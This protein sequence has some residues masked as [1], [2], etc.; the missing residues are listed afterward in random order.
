MRERLK[1]NIGLKLLAFLF[2]FILWLLVVNIDDP[3]KTKT[4]DN[5]PV[6]VEHEEVITTTDTK[7][8]QIIDNTQ[9]VSVSISAVRSVL[10]KIK[11]EDIVA[12][13][14]MRELYLD[15]LVPI[16]VQVRGYKVD[17]AVA[18]PR[19]LRVK[20]ENN[21]SN[22]FPI[23]PVTTGTVRDGY[24]LGTI[25]ADP[26]KVTINGPESVV[27]RISKVIAEV[28]VSGLSQDTKLESSLTL[29]DA[30]NN[31]I[32]QSLLGNNLGKIGVNIDV[33]LLHTK[34]VPVHVDQTSIEAADGFSV[35]GVSYSPQEI[36]LAGEEEVLSHITGIYVPAEAI[37]EEK[38]SRKMEKTI[39]ITPYLPEHTRLVDETGNNLL[40]TITVEKDGTRNLDLP[41]GSISVKN[42]DD[43][44]KMSYAGTDDLE[45]HIR[46]PRE[47]L[48]NYEV[49]KKASI[50]LSELKMA[51]TYTVSVEIELPAGCTLENKV[52]VQ[53]VLEKKEESGG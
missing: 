53:V 34:S 2:A 28:D 9:T 31:V 17:S 6:V 37:G 52:E 50:D 24:V 16:E 5:I 44:L 27:E 8:Y 1:N 26:E 4:Y 42:L 46:G 10:S 19:N 20:I 43:S 30:E 49:D 14:D 51:G 15:S 35:A 33:T 21:A 39:D 29:Y 11:A 38:I 47:V 3:V 18:N 45:I 12:V 7:T 48:E 36:L 22:T 40:I 23:T 32:D 13:A 25:K 41:V